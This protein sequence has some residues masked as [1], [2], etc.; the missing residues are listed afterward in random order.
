MRR[1]FLPVAVSL[2]FIGWSPFMGQ[3]RDTIKAALGDAFTPVL[4]QLFFNLADGFAGLT[5]FASLFGILAVRTGPFH[6]VA[7]A[8]PL[9]WGS[10]S[11]P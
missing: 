5:R 2:L 10:R 3:L 8:S 4:G 9:F 1:Y 7:H 11:S 6:G